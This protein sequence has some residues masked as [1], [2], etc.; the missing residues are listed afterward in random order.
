MFCFVRHKLAL[1]TAP[2]LQ[3]E[4]IAATATAPPGL[5]PVWRSAPLKEVFLYSGK[6][7]EEKNVVI[8]QAPSGN[9]QFQLLPA[10]PHHISL[11]LQP[12]SEFPLSG[13]GL[14]QQLRPGRCQG[15]RTAELP[16]GLFVQPAARRARAAP[17]RQH[18]G[19][20]RSSPAHPPAVAAPGFPGH[21]ETCC[22]PAAAPGPR[23][24][25]PWGAL[26]GAPR[27]LSRPLSAGATRRC[28]RSGDPAASSASL[29]NPNAAGQ[30]LQQTP[31]RAAGSRSSRTRP[32][33]AAGGRRSSAGAAAP[34][35]VGAATG[36]TGR[37][38]AGDG[39]ERRSLL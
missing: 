26:H 32:R 21:R 22:R 8:N 23:S 18:T 4:N 12:S 2:P 9:G 16:R 14:G 10:S 37:G 15:A 25:P 34:P 39:A 36:R 35:R 20:L 11:S 19:V 3:N 5:A 38:S 29:R 7:G 24:V 28:W 33:P 30:R 27:P 17:Q 1:D 6:G 13:L 31:P